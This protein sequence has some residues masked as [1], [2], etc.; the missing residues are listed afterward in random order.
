M[1]NSKLIGISL[2]LFLLFATSALYA[3]PPGNCSVATL[4]GSYGFYGYT[5]ATL[6]MDPAMRVAIAGIIRFDGK[7]HLSGESIGNVEGWGAGGVA[8]FE[9]TYTVNPD[10]T[11]SGEHTGDGET[12]H[13]VETITGEGMTQETRFVVTDPGWVALGFERKI[14][15]AGCSLATLKGSYALFGEGTVTGLRPPIPMSH[16]G[17]VTFDGAGTFFGSDTIM[18]GGTMIAD[19]FTGTYAVTEECMVTASIHSDVVGDV[20]QVGWIVGEGKS[21]EE[22]LI[23]T[24]PGFLFVETT[25]KQ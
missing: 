25:R 21:T 23:V 5:P 22:H 16:V 19:M 10:C 2:A 12:L 13:F 18:L 15:P 8:T 4:N 7:G 9:G 24:N 20:Q 14:Q 11:Y 17:T 3:A 6:V 1:S